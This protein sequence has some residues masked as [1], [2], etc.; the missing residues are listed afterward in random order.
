MTTTPAHPSF[1]Q[2]FFRFGPHAGAH[3]VAARAG[4]SVFVPLTLLT[5]TGHLDWS[6][7]A[8]FGA[9]TSLYGRAAPHA[10]RTALQMTIA[11]VL[12][13]AVTLGCA[14]G[15]LPH[16]Q[17]WLI[18][19]GAL[20][21]AAASLLSD[22]FRWHPPGPLFVVFAFTVCAT[23]PAAASNVAAGFLVS[24]ASAAFSVLI[25]RVGL[26]R[27]TGERR[28]IPLPRA[29]IREAWQA[30]GTRVHL[31]R[32]VI[33]VGAAGVVG[34]LIGTQ[35]GGSH[36]YWA[37]V[38]A[39]AGLSGATHRARMI[40]GGQRFV[41]TLFGVLAAAA[42]L[43]WHPQGFAAVLVITALQVGAELLVGRN[44][45]LALLCIT[46]LALMMGQIVHEVPVGPLLVDRA[47]ETLIGC[48]VALVVLLVVR[49][50]A[51]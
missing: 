41:G 9:F 44:Y 26:L 46:P 7:F 1:L 10:E 18:A 4:V 47:V 23:L 32:F 30:E 27:E 16:H 3:R 49:D 24:A 35:Y 11:G 38:A 6:A 43:P 12:V 28:W 34:K 37:M 15:L 40:R 25:G 39:V 22:A 33:A 50:P 42:I 20:V 13:M 2:E 48:G 8:A 19:A 45:A 14:V 17:W 51:H 31:A 5:V 21:A 36:P 29:R